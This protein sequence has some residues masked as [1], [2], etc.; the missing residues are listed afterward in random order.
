MRDLATITI[1]KKLKFVE[2]NFSARST[3]TDL[4]SASLRENIFGNPISPSSLLRSIFK[5]RFLIIRIPF[6]RIDIKC[7]TV[8]DNGVS[9]N[10]LN[11]E[12]SKHI[13]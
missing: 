9:R 6:N 12:D 10:A 1:E 3:E 8:G 4:K 13:N 5:I 11:I 7:L 2:I